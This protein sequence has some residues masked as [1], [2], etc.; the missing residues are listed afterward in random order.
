MNVIISTLSTWTQ[1]DNGKHN[2][3]KHTYI[4]AHTRT[5]TNTHSLGLS[6]GVNQPLHYRASL[7]FWPTGLLCKQWTGSPAAAHSH[8]E[9]NMQHTKIYRRRDKNGFRSSFHS[10][11]SVLLS[12]YLPTSFSVSVSQRVGPSGVAP[13]EQAGF[14][15]WEDTSSKVS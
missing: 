8:T 9:R 15:T 6:R 7:V 10:P 12:L 14:S 2:V 1:A 5:Q 13:S 4:Y 11:P 3:N